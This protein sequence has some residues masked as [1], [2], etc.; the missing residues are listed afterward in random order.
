MSNIFFHRF[1][2]LSIIGCLGGD[3][4]FAAALV[5]ERPL[6]N[7]LAVLQVRFTEQVLSPVSG[8]IP[9]EHLGHTSVTLAQMTSAVFIE[10]VG[11]ALRRWKH[12]PAVFG[13]LHHQVTIA[14]SRPLLSGHSNPAGA[15]ILSL[16]FFDQLHK[17]FV[18]LSAFADELPQAWQDSRTGQ[19]TQSSA[20][21]YAKRLT[22][23]ARLWSDLYH[24]FGL[25]HFTE[26]VIDYIPARRQKW[27]APLITAISA[28]TEELQSTVIFIR[29]MPML[30]PHPV[31]SILSAKLIAGWFPEA[32][33]ACENH[34][35]PQTLIRGD[36]LALSNALRNIIENALYYAG[37]R[38][39]GHPV[40]PRVKVTLSIKGGHVHIQV[41]D[42]GPGISAAMRALDPEGKERLYHLN[43]SDRPGG[44]GQGL[45][46]AWYCIRAAGGS[47]TVDSLAL[48]G[49]T[50]TIQLPIASSRHKTPNRR[51]SRT[52]A[53]QA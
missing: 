25:E 24:C 30:T 44:T 18:K 16:T 19:L 37:W 22:N 50:F 28:I 9:N 23:L 15:G 27:V 1:V 32:T 47:I 52:H 40:S 48:E 34:V 43:A 21:R 2:I 4:T 7:S 53:T 51:R 46:D 41:E 8:E 6:P 42:N 20:D 26:S 12:D 49:T 13:L 38:P 33:I 14:V 3:P 11:I 31:E 36:R 29:G 35:P 45:A 39:N 10:R 17:A 5:S